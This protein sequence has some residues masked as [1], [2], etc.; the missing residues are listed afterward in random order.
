MLSERGLCSRDSEGGCFGKV[1]YQNSAHGLEVVVADCSGFDDFFTR[2]ILPLGMGFVWDKRC[3][4][5]SQPISRDSL[6]ANKRQFE[7]LIRSWLP[8]LQRMPTE[9]M[10]AYIRASSRITVS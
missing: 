9:V 2:E 10:I 5:L 6:F 3:L 4:A 8:R 1:L 7:T